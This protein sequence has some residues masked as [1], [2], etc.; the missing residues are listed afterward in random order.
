MDFDINLSIF[1]KNLLPR[2]LAARCKVVSLRDF[3]D[4]DDIWNERNNLNEIKFIFF[5]YLII[6]L[7]SNTRSCTK[8]NLNFLQFQHF[9]YRDD[10]SSCSL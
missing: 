1:F 2:A 6:F 10:L 3:G 8:T 9:E 7:K 5:L 4:F